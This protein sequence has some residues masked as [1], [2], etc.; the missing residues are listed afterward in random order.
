MPQTEVSGDDV[1]DYADLVSLI[2]DLE[3]VLE[4]AR[5]LRIQA[6]VDPRHQVAG[7]L[8]ESM[9]ITY[10]RCF[11][12]GKSALGKRPRR[13]MPDE[14][15]SGLTPQL[16]AAHELVMQL[17]N[18]HVGHR[19]GE[20]SGVRVVAVHEEIGG[21]PVGVA[22]LRVHLVLPDNYGD[23][24]EV[25]QGLLE[26]LRPLAEQEAQAILARLQA[27]HEAG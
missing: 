4:V 25:T 20:T 6:A 22:W 18:K 3:R 27:E 26:H 23:L 1:L 2:G 5:S 17:R 11:T 24:E 7:A 19:V 12:S 9:V 16:R 14:A 10:G 15:L 13:R 8:W 21:P